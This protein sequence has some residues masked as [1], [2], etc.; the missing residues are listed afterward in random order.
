MPRAS[1]SP[2]AQETAIGSARGKGLPEAWNSPGEVWVAG[3][4][5]LAGMRIA[6]RR[7]SPLQPQQPATVRYLWA[8]LLHRPPS[9]H[10]QCT[11]LKKSPARLPR[12]AGSTSSAPKNS[13]PQKRSFARVAWAAYSTCYPRFRVR[14]IRHCRQKPSAVPHMPVPSPQKP[15]PSS[16]SDSGVQKSD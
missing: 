10:G 3:R 14:Y 1:P 7:T 2:C 15:M 16:L 12:S 8:A 5:S 9:H 13:Y 4:F 11:P 6:R